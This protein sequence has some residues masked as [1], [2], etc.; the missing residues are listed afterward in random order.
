VAVTRD[1]FVGRREELA[2]LRRRCAE[3]RAGSGHLVLVGGPAGIG[4]TRLVEEVVAAATA[5]G[6][7][8][9]WGAAVDDAGMPALWPWIRALRALAAPREALTRVVA[10][11][12]QR[13]Y[14][15]AEDAAALTFA[16]DT[17]VVDAVADCAGATSGLVIVIEDLQWA[18]Q[19]TL[20]LLER[21]TAEIRRLPLIVLV[22][23]RDGAG[24][25]LAGQ[26]I[27]NA[28]DVLSLG[29][30]TLGEA[31]ELLTGSVESA[32]PDA[33]RHAARVSGGSPLYLRTLGR[34]AG[35]QLRGRVPWGEQVGEAPELR[36]LIAAAMRTAGPTAGA[37]V[38]AL[39]VLGPEA[40]PEVLARLIGVHP[41]SAVVERLH[42]A[43]PAGLLVAPSPADGGP[44]RF[45]HALVRD[46]VYASLP[47]ARRTVLHRRAAQLLE[48]LAI[49]RDDRAGAVARHWHRAG[50]PARAV[51]WA[52]RAA[53]AAGAAAAY[54]EAASYLQL[55]LTATEQAR[56]RADGDPVDGAELLLDLARMQYLAGRILPSV[57]TSR[58]AADE[59]ERSGR[60]EMVARAALIVQGVGD[61]AV[62]RHIEAICRRALAMLGER[63][64]LELR[65][66]VQAQLACALLMLGDVDGATPWSH[67]ALADAAASGD[68]NAELDAIR[69]RA[70][71]VWQPGDIEEMVEL[72]RRSIEL[73]EQAG[74]PLA[75]LW[76]Y[77][78]LADNAVHRGDV[79][80]THLAMTGLRALAEGTGLPL[81][82]WHLLRRQA[83]LAILGGNFAGWRRL[84]GQAADIAAEWQDLSVWGTHFSQSV[85][86][87]L[88]RGDP[89]DLAPEW[90]DRLDLATVMP[91]VGQG[92]FAA[93]LYMVGRHDEARALY[94][95][96]AQLVTGAKSLFTVAALQPLIE[97]AP[98]LGSPD[99]CRGI[100]RLIA[101]RFGHSPVIGS[102]I[103]AFTGSVDRVVAEL[104][105]GS[106]DPRAAIPHFEAGLR[107]ESRIGAW[108]YVARG[109]MGLA[110]ALAATGEHQ[111][112]VALARAAAAGA[113]RLDMP[114]LL[115]A[116]DTFL[117]DT[118][119]RARAE[120]PLSQRERE[121]VELVA[122]ALSN[123]EV[124]R[125]LVLSERTV[126]AHVRRIL[127]KTGHSSRT[128]LVR[129]FLTRP[130]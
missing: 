16:A 113:R 70:D 98:V 130:S 66:R 123:R 126:E 17:A 129:W 58:R 63:S 128:E 80:A 56:T 32:D 85:I 13:E 48:P 61:P 87:A 8:T 47:P 3:A 73:A 14:G 116:A 23:V 106:G 45:A 39:S 40:E 88:L 26:L 124:A 112:A 46:A 50:E 35:D 90:V 84:A 60:P 82:R 74:R 51:V 127:A 28:T 1:P 25:S 21:V 69:A 91:P 109:Q 94:Q 24:G 33:V 7:P 18:D 121:V 76:G 93:A 125:R 19:A 42:P 20:R 52:V 100:R 29:P 64:A 15:S 10:G 86:V 103:V 54:D 114:G 34:T 41:A 79:A 105:L 59:G 44:I 9:G 55:A 111:R 117:A 27:R 81:V 53:D 110:R 38:Q 62:N 118:A 68:P 97:L 30:L 4:K 104:E 119:A 122:Q 67:R 5:D 95:P 57:R 89:G 22:T 102:G 12:L 78:W 36:H 6:V 11:A 101:G 2:L 92:T 108:P 65:A 49:G 75:K 120:D 99:D 31:I 96:L 72:G 83:A 77:G 71:L 43:V 107:L 115:H 37:A